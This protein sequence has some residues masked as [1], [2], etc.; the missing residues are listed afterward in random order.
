MRSLISKLNTV[1]SDEQWK[2]VKRYN[3]N[4]VQ[5]C[6]ERSAN[7]VE[8][9][10]VNAYVDSFAVDNGKAMVFVESLNN[11]T[12]C[13]FRNNFSFSVLEKLVLPELIARKMKNKTHT[14]RVWSMASAGGQELYSIAILLDELKHLHSES[15]NIQLF[16][17]DISEQQITLAKQGIYKHKDIVHVTEKRLKQYFNL[18]SDGNYALN[19]M[20][21]ENVSISTFD[22]TDANCNCPPESVFGDFDLVVCANVLIYY[23]T[24]HT[25]NI[26]DKI[27]K[28]MAKN[29]FVMT[30]ESER[31]MF[32]K[33]GFVEFSSQSGIYC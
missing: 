22:L 24:E 11:S 19:Q 4:Y 6:L 28:C 21:F 15:I 9:S 30:G 5:K 31:D 2:I 12:S 3:D 23:N 29:A 26:F 16:A 10:V 14:L 8:P 27:N 13:F 1:L 17:T 7:S 33:R 32:E 18:Q 25:N 20:L